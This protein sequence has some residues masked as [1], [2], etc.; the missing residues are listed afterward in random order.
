MHRFPCIAHT[1]QLVIKEMNKSPTYSKLITKVKALVKF[2][3]GSSV[4][5]EKLIGLA[6]KHE[7]EFGVDDD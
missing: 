6:S 1:L 2:V 5:Q 4:L 7:V 3:R